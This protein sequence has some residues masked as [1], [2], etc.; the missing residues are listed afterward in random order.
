MIESAAN[1]AKALCDIGRPA[2]LS[3]IAPEC[4][5]FGLAL[6]GARPLNEAFQRRPGRSAILLIVLENDLYRRTPARQVDS[7]AKVGARTVIVLD[8]LANP[9]HRE[10][11]TA[12]SRR[13]ICRIRWNAGQQRRARTEVFPGVRAARR[14]AGEL[15]MA[16]RSDMVDRSMMFLTAMAEG[17]SRTSRRDARPRRPSEFPDGWREDS[18]RAA[19]L[20][21]AHLHHSRT[22]VSSNP[23]RREDPDSALAYSMEGAPLPAALRTRHFSGLPAGTPSRR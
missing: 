12:S 15:A 20:Q 8:H 21:R 18:A 6:M 23:N 4:N 14:G 17:D 11:G 16:A 7:I 19:P 1:V 22:S 10:S 5:S 3:L 13:H 9:N 2:A